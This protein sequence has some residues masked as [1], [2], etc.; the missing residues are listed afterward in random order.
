MNRAS[1]KPI[2]EN[3]ILLAWR[4][5]TSMLTSLQFQSAAR[6]DNRIASLQPLSLAVVN[7]CIHVLFI[8]LF[9][10]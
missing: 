8:Y 6:Y 3:V 5:H 10:V 1:W 2:E 9:A 7:L 4:E